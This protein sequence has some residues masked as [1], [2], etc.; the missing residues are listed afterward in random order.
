[1]VVPDVKPFVLIVH[2]REVVTTRLITSKPCPDLNELPVSHLLNDL[3]D[4]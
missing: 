3:Q 4:S 1:M 2:D